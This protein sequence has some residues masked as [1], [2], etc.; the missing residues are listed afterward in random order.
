MTDLLGVKGT[1]VVVFGGT[2][3]IGLAIAEA[4]ARAGANVVVTGRDA[5][6]GATVVAA[7]ESFGVRAYFVSCDITDYASVQ[8][9]VSRSVELLGKID[10]AV[11]SASGRTKTA[12][13]FRP[14]AEIDAADIGPYAHT[15]WVSKA[16]CVKAVLDHMRDSGGGKIV[17]ITSDSG[18][19][20]TVG[21]SL[22]GGSAAAMHNMVRTV[23][24]E[25]ARW[26]INVNS[27]AITVTDTGDWDKFISEGAGANPQFA[28]KM[29]QKLAKRQIIHVEGRHVADAVLFLGS[30]MSDAVTGQILSVNG[31]VST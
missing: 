4:Y 19:S 9:S 18:K 26:K 27:V 22:I 16:Y 7:L 31:G 3:K 12:Q 23:A 21:E 17:A 11:A 20:P 10:V 25:F 6:N 29:F 13:G 15:H 8:A 30:R 28:S 1:G 2:R 24:K 5:E 14:F